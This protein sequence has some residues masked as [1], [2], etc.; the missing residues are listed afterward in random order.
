MG[1]GFTAY[2]RREKISLTVQ[3]Y[4]SNHEVGASGPRGSVAMVGKMI[5]EGPWIK[6]LDDEQGQAAA[7]S[8]DASSPKIVL[9]PENSVVQNA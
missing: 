7:I 2:R 1:G 4:G 6:Q 9:R 8:E 3:W 5:P